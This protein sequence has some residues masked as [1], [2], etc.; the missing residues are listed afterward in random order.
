VVQLLLADIIN[1]SQQTQHFQNL[2]SK[3]AHTEQRTLLF[4][5]LGV[6]A[7]VHL[8]PLSGHNLSEE[9]TM[10][11]A[12]AGIINLFAR[13]D[14]KYLSYL[15]TWLTSVNGAGLGD[16]IG[17]RRAVLAALSSDRDTM[18]TVF[19]KSL[20]QFGDYLY[21]RHTPVLQQEGMQ[22]SMLCSSEIADTWCRSACASASPERW[23]S[24]EAVA[25]QIVLNRE[26]GLVHEYGL[27]EIG[28]IPD[29]RP[30]ARDDCW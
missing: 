3:L 30:L 4:S 2:F 20:V 29:P 22:D 26:I 19:E 18:A 7:G 12:A 13:S 6:I 17:I 15:V 5:I 23:I 27:Q 9:K 11:S 14:A 28:G 24:P 8:N 16:A 21:I 10:I 1:N 25:G